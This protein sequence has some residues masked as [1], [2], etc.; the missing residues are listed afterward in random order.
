MLRSLQNLPSAYQPLEPARRPAAKPEKK[1]GYRVLVHRKYANH[2]EQAVERVG[3]Q[4]VQQ[5]WDHV[6]QTPGATSPV[7]SITILKG[8]AGRPQGAGWSRTYHYELSGAARINYQFHNEFDDGAKGDKH[9][10]VAILTI[11]FSSH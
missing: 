6:A 5:F 10:V 1:P 4:Q 9:R 7:A 8:K 3:L 2:W 11:D